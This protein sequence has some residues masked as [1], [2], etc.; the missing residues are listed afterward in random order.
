MLHMY[1]GIYKNTT[2]AQQASTVSN[3]DDFNSTEWNWIELVWIKF[4]RIELDRTELDWY[5][6]HAIFHFYIFIMQA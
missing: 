4:I 1:V 6:E 5:G 2:Q 3:W